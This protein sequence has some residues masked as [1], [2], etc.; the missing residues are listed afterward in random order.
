MKMKKLIL[1]LFSLGSAF[2]QN[3]GQNVVNVAL[4]PSANLVAPGSITLTYP[5]IQNI[6][7][8]SH[9]VT[10]RYSSVASGIYS[11]TIQGSWDG[12]NYFNISPVA[13]ANTSASAQNIGILQNTGYQSFPYIRVVV[14][15]N[16]S[17]DVI[18]GVY[19]SGSSAPS[20][21]ISENSGRE[22]NI[23]TIT[24][25][26]IP[27]GSNTLFVSAVA[28][29]SI[30]IYSLSIYPSAGAT[31]FDMWCGRSNADSTKDKDIM[32]VQNLSGVGKVEWGSSLRQYSTCPNGDAIWVNLTSSSTG[33]AIN[34]SYRLE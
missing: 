11:S 9:N 20:V 5:N 28:G 17:S 27:T 4:R 21:V 29:A 30:S 24:S 31:L 1:V 32:N 33:V 34:M 12:T 16:N 23:N 25:S 2:G 6:G 22:S 8:S 19:Y 7:Q 15:V 26:S 18:L 10:V 13:V 3:T 14:T